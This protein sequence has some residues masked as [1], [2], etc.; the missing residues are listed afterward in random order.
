MLC[1]CSGIAVLQIRTQF[2]GMG[3][4]RTSEAHTGCRIGW[5]CL[6]QNIASLAQNV[7]SNILIS[8]NDDLITLHASKV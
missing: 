4:D 8:Q 6:R 2:P 3:D 1:G 7:G 5:Q